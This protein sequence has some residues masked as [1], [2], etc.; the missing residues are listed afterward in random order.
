MNK[1]TYKGKNGILIYSVTLLYNLLPILM[2]QSINWNWFSYV[3]LLF[4]YMFDFLMFPII[5]RNR[6]EVYD[7]YF[8]FYYGFGKHRYELAKI[9]RMERTTNPI[10]ASANSLDRIYIDFGGD[11][12]SISLQ[13]NDGFMSCI[14]AKGYLS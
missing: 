3:I 4:Y 6:V 2:I 8:L 5:I 12:L 11:D 14:R 10:A 13:D 9:R 1:I 7:D